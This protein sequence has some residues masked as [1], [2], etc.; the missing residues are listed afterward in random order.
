M[1]QATHGLRF[2]FFDSVWGTNMSVLLCFNFN[3]NELIVRKAFRNVE[4][5]ILGHDLRWRVTLPTSITQSVDIL[6]DR[7]CADLIAQHLVQ[8]S[9]V[10]DHNGL[11]K[12]DLS[13]FELLSDNQYDCLNTESD[14]VDL[15][16]QSLVGTLRPDRPL[17]L[18]EEPEGDLCEASGNYLASSR[19]VSVATDAGVV[20]TLGDVRVGGRTESAWKR[21]IQAPRSAFVDPT[22]SLQVQSSISSPKH[23]SNCGIW[24]SNGSLEVAMAIEESGWFDA[25]V[26]HPLFATKPFVHNI[27]VRCGS[28]FGTHP[29]VERNSPTGRAISDIFYRLKPYCSDFKNK[30]LVAD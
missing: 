9:F 21:I 5:A 14:F 2:D 30:N 29:V 10:V 7:G 16:S 27:Q 19:F 3:A 12:D 20:L 22:L 11:R 8:F 17:I 24:L 1:V 13:A 15:P 4:A 18:G 26:E 23:R 28:D 25:E 6:C